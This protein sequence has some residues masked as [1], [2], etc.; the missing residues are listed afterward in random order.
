[1]AYHSQVFCARGAPFPGLRIVP[2]HQ[3]Q[4]AM[5]AGPIKCATKCVDRAEGWPPPDIVEKVGG[6]QVGTLKQKTPPDRGEDRVQGQPQTQPRPRSP[7]MA[8][9]ARHRRQRKPNKH[10]S[11]SG[12]D[13]N[14]NNNNGSD[15]SSNNSNNNNMTTKATTTTTSGRFKISR[16]SSRTR[17]AR[18][19]PRSRPQSS[20]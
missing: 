10:T 16:C 9:D 3:H 15:S 19:S 17:P 18:R 2:L 13:N 1:M 5:K 8:Q 14:N 11:V 6:V 20:T 4:I 12:N 7:Q